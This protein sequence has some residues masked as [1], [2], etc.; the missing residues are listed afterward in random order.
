MTDPE[1]NLTYEG[2][3]RIGLILSRPP[4]GLD[5]ADLPFWQRGHGAARAVAGETPRVQHFLLPIPER[6]G[7]VPS[8]PGW[9]Q[10]YSPET[11]LGWNLGIPMTGAGLPETVVPPFLPPAWRSPAARPGMVPSVPIPSSRPGSPP[12][13]PPASSLEEAETSGVRIPPILPPPG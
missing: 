3:A 1:G 7:R 9:E 8:V 4:K 10:T 13:A 2:L 12:P 5:V 6:L 11:R